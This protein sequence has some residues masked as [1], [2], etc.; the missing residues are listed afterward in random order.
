MLAAFKRALTDEDPDLRYATLVA[1]PY[2]G[3]PE[4]KD[5]VRQL[6]RENPSDMVRSAADCLLEGYEQQPGPAT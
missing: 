4:L 1:I 5:S 2:S 6:S 3:W